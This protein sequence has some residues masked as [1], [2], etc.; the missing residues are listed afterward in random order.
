MLYNATDNDFLLSMPVKPSVILASRMASSYLMSIIYEAVLYIPAL[1]QY[2]VFARPGA[3]GMIFPSL[4][5]FISGFA[6][7]AL[8]CLFGW[9]M[10]AASSRIRNRNYFI[11]AASLL[12]VGLYYAVIF[13][14]N[15]L[16][17]IVVSN[18]ERIAVN[19]RRF[20]FPLFLFGSG[21]CGNVIHFLLFFAFAAV[22]FII[23]LAAMSASFIKLATANRGL[24]KKGYRS[25]SVKSGSAKG[26][27]LR[28][29]K[30]RF[31]NTPLLFINSGLGLFIGPAA[32]IAALVK[33]TA[34][35]QIIT[36]LPSKEMIPGMVVAA[37]C[38]ICTIGEMTSS[39]VSLEGRSMWILQSMPVTTSSILWAKIRFAFTVTIPSAAVSL[40]LFSIAFRISPLTVALM[41][42]AAAANIL[43]ITSLGLVFNLRRP[44]LE[45]T[46]ETVPIKQ[47][48]PILLSM[49]AGF[50]LS[51]L[52]GG[53]AAAMMYLPS[54]VSVS[55][56]AVVYAL[57]LIPVVRWI[58]TKGVKK[59][60][61]I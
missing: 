61:E 29:E 2:G 6:V 4:N 43:L 50:A 14:F 17:N 15:D 25:D 34:L 9:L 49:L 10:A 18:P 55:A 5:M 42:I 3:A 44:N 51:A 39:S 12:A 24:K 56:C 8:T 47:D 22:I 28:K 58:N 13:K 53:V 21:S 52:S 60:E 45:W 59:F 38:L 7:L 1:I 36:S 27:L 46:N 11:T 33:S 31:L 16:V 48:S 30:N 20:A 35:N 32:A 23:T 57:I 37:V 54:A 41:M 19:M 40:I 26:A